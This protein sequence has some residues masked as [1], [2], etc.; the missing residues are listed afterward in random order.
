MSV[1]L[2]PYAAPQAAVGDVQYEEF[3][4]VSFFSAAGRLGRV[5]YLGY[6]MG[7]YFLFG[8]VIGLVAAMGA[9][10]GMRNN[11]LFFIPFGIAYVGMMVMGAMQAIQRC[12]D[13]DKSGWFVLLMLVPL[14]NMLFAL[15]LTFM[16]GTDGPNRFGARPVPNSAGVIIL[17]CLFPLIFI[18]ILAAVAIPAYSQYTARAHMR[19]AH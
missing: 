19:A 6:L 3:Q 16:P 14:L 10:L 15:Y 11:S 1:Q 4:E 17:A 5:R 12:H 2:N 9:G 7:T 8:L 13:C 18:G